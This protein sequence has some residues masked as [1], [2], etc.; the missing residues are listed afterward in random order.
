MM[1]GQLLAARLTGL[2]RL[3]VHTT[4]PDDYRRALLPLK[5]VDGVPLTLADG[6][7]PRARRKTVRA[8]ATARMGR[9]CHRA[10]AIVP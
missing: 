5:L 4:T 1:L 7:C 2:D 3:V 6:H 8:M 9:A 10:M